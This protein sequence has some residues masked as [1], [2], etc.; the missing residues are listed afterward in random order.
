MHL[1]GNAF[2]IPSVEQLLCR[3]NELFSPEEKRR[4]Q[5]LYENWQYSYKWENDT[6]REVTPTPRGEAVSFKR[7]YF[8]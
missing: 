6:P 1:I 3:L 5:E 7:E 4:C 2:S 8:I